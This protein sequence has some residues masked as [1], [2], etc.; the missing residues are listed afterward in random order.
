MMT[1]KR[2]P[3]RLIWRMAWRL[4]RSHKGPYLSAV[5]LIS[6]G[7]VVLGVAS[8]VVIFSFTSGFEEVFRD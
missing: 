8:L 1:R 5:T 7:G 2:V 3:S 6:I 4:L